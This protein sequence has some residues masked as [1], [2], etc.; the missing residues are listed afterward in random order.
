ML[1]SLLQLIIILIVSYIILS[2][3]LIIILIVSYI[4][5]SLQLIIILIVSYIILSQLL[6]WFKKVQF[7]MMNRA[8]IDELQRTL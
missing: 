6:E 4:I 1:I 7:E 8:F 2:L 3:Q 5:L